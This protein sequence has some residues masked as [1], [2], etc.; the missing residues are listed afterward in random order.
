MQK[1]DSQA[2]A[3]HKDSLSAALIDTKTLKTEIG[4]VKDEILR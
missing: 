2:A 3:V 4:E 1:K